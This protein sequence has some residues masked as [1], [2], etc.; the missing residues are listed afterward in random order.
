MT[1]QEACSGVPKMARQALTRCQQGAFLFGCDTV[2]AWQVQ[3][4][5][6]NKPENGINLLVSTY[7]RAHD[8]C[9]PIT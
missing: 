5:G 7:C 6:P 4:V 9:C 1:V 8:I 3:T 2:P